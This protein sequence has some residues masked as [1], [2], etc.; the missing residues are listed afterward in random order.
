MNSF[1]VHLQRGIARRG[2]VAE[3]RNKVSENPYQ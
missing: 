2:D 1:L 3:E